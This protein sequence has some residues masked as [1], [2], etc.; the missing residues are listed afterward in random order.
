MSAAKLN[1]RT[2]PSGMAPKKEKFAA[3]LDSA[4]PPPDRSKY[5]YLV[6]DNYIEA[7]DYAHAHDFTMST[8]RFVSCPEVLKG[9]ESPQVIVIGDCTR[10]P[11]QIIEALGRKGARITYDKIG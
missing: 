7:I 10:V 11:M 6:A 2:M 3:P 1:I 9:V 5:I 4:L 8:T